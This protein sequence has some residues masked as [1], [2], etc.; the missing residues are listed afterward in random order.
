MNFQARLDALKNAI[1]A[2]L[3][4]R[5]TAAGLADFEEYIADTPRLTDKRQLAVFQGSGIIEIDREEY[6]VLVHATLPRIE[7]PTGYLGAIVDSIRSINPTV[8]GMQT[9]VSVEYRPLYSG[10][11]PEGGFGSYIE[12]SLIY[13]KEFDDCD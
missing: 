7:V 6:E 13:I 2:D 9:L 3:P 11:P 5:L 1:A 4:A 8:V 12:H 10:A